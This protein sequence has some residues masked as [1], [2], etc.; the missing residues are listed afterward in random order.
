MSDKLDEI[1]TDFI[2]FYFTNETKEEIGK[3]I[4][5]YKFNNFCEKNYT[6]GLYY[7]GVK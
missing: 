3:I 5:L 6:R 2:H 1:K 7:R 4:S